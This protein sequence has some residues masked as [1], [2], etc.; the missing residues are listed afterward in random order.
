MNLVE[1]VKTLS[2]WQETT[3]IPTV[4]SRLHHLVLVSATNMNNHTNVQTMVRN[5]L[6]L[7]EFILVTRIDLIMAKKSLH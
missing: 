2:N 6:A 1:M 3:G 5:V 4:P 7:V